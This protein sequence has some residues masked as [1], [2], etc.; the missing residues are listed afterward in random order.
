MKRKVAQ[1][2]NQNQTRNSKKNYVRFLTSKY[3]KILFPLL[4]YIKA[5]QHAFL[6]IF[7][8]ISQKTFYKACRYEYRKFKLKT[9]TILT[10]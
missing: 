2:F 5:L 3:S 8:C 6:C 4:N 9:K 10:I 1:L 7:I